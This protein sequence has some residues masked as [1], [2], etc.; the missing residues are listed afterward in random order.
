MH[1]PNGGP[2]PAGGGQSLLGETLPPGR[3]SSRRTLCT[4]REAYLARA[5][6]LLGAISSG[7]IYEV[8]Y[9]IERRAKAIGWDPFP[10]KFGAGTPRSIPA[11]ADH[12]VLC[13]SPESFLR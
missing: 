10:V 4:S 7:D 1:L 11:I 3:Q 8:N 12:F 2:P 6:E 9:C 5:R 13:A